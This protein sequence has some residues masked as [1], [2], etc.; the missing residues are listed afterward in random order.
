MRKSRQWGCGC[1]PA[2][3]IRSTVRKPSDECPRSAPFLLSLQP[4]TQ[5][6]GSM[7][8]TLGRSSHFKEHSHHSPSQCAWSFACW[9]IPN[10]VK[11]MINTNHHMPMFIPDLVTKL[12][13]PLSTQWAGCMQILPNFHLFPDCCNLWTH[14]MSFYFPYIQNSPSF[15]HLHIPVLF[16]MSGATTVEC[17]L[18]PQAQH[19]LW[20]TLGTPD[21]DSSFVPYMRHTRCPHQCALRPCTSDAC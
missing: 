21:S 17:P 5:T 6:H 18:V 8:P 3:H 7:P 2:D 12:R 11:L 4:R 16:R 20:C 14:R 9:E 13:R 1:G 10:R 15:L 19:V